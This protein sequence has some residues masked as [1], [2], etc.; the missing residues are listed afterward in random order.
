MK[1]PS[2]LLAEKNYEGT[3]LLELTDEKLTALQKELNVLQVEAN[4]HLLEM[5]KITPSLDPLF[6]KIRELNEEMKKVQDKKAPLQ[7]VY[8]EW[9]KKVEEID[10]RAQLIKNKIEPLV[11]KLIEGQLGEFE[12]ATTMKEKDGKI[13]VEIVDEIEEKVKAIRAI[14]K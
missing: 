12:K 13:F 11:K 14:K 3:R 4:P 8:N 7:E 6:T 5:E 1:I 10:Q 9:L 2:E